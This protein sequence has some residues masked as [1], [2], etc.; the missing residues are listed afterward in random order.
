[1]RGPRVTQR[2]GYFQDRIAALSADRR[3]R[4]GLS[5]RVPK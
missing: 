1:M 5:D 3:S 2:P 4:V